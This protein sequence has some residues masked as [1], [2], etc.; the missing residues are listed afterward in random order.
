[1]THRTR[2]RELLPV[3]NVLA[4]NY[5]DGPKWIPGVIVQQLGPL[6]YSVQVRDGICW[7]HHIDQLRESSEAVYVDSPDSTATDLY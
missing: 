7:R 5:H 6:T 3:Q 1:M 4:Q 2:Q